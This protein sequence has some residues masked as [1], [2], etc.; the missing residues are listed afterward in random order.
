MLI[1]KQADAHVWVRATSSNS[2]DVRV[3][4]GTQVGVQGQEKVALSNSWVQ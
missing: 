3:E 4:I 2:S 1:C